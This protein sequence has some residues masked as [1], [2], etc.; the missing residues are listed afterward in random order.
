MIDNIIDPLLHYVRITNDQT[1]IIIV[2]DEF[3]STE[4]IKHSHYIN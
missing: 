2:F 3:T 4:G 1:N